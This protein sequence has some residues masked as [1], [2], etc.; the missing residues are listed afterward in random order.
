MV[1]RAQ[2]AT[3][4]CGAKT[5]MRDRDDGNLSGSYCPRVPTHFLQCR[6]RTGKK[7]EEL[8][9]GGGLGCGQGTAACRAGVQGRHHTG[10]ELAPGRIDGCAIAPTPP[11]PPSW[12]PCFHFHQ[13]VAVGARFPALSFT[14]LPHARRDLEPLGE[15]ST[16]DSC[17]Y[18]TIRFVHRCPGTCVRHITE[19]ADLI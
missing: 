11:L 2:F 15:G 4:R 10:R 19:A 13:V 8:R 3:A 9:R 1:L 5:A 6:R 18:A 12:R 7:A 14:R 16:A 17:R